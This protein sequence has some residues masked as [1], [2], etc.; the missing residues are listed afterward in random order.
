MR[1]RVASLDIVRSVAIALVLGRHL[2][3]DVPET[4]PRALRL[5]VEAWIRGGWTGVDLFFVLSGFLVSGLLW[6]DYLRNGKLNVVR[7]YFRRG[8][9]IYPPFAVLLIVT[10]LWKRPVDPARTAAE[11]LFLQS[12]LPGLWPHTWSLGVEEH[13]YLCLPLLSLFIVNGRTPLPIRRIAVIGIAVLT[14]GLAIRLVHASMAG[15]YAH[16]T[17]TYP[18][19]LRVDAL[20]FGALLGYAW[21]FHRAAC[22]RLKKWTVWCMAAGVLGF[23]PPFIWPLELTAGMYTVGFTVLTVASALIVISAALTVPSSS[24]ARGCAWIGRDS[25]AIYLWHFPVRDWALPPLVA[26]F[27][28]GTLGAMAA[29]VLMSVGAGMIMA[30]LVERPAL[31]IRDRWLPDPSLRDTVASGRRPPF[32]SAPSGSEVGLT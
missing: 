7:F 32:A 1:S 16:L 6:S 2:N 29:Y 21:H 12:Y 27:Q 31:A 20:F 11:V 19:H 30:R 9:K 13:F 17:H 4:W 26:A 28:L 25:Y 5:F 8:W 22:E 14:C 23:V 18:T 10:V 3:I 24:L 15:S